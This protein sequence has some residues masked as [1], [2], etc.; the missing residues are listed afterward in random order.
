MRLVLYSVG[1]IAAS[2][3]ARSAM[4]AEVCSN[5]LNNKAMTVA[6]RVLKTDELTTPSA[7]PGGAPFKVL[8]VVV[9]DEASGCRIVVSIP[10]HCIVGEFAR[11]S[12]GTTGFYK[13]NLGRDYDYNYHSADVLTPDEKVITLRCTR[14]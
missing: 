3:V 7:A 12:G 14:Q 6:G 13:G 1:V 2:I 9:A 5:G 10:A 8:R 11:A 4:A